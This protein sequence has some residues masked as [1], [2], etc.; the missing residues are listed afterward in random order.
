[1]QVVYVRV[2]KLNRKVLSTYTKFC[3]KKLIAL[4]LD[5]GRFSEILVVKILQK[6]SVKPK[7]FGPCFMTLR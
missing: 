6:A 1:M 3:K 7:T 2:S 4:F 5:P